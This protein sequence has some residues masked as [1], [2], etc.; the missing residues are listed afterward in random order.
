MNRIV[1]AVALL[2]SLA[3][4]YPITI[5]AASANAMSDTHVQLATRSVTI[6]P[7][8]LPLPVG[9]G[10]LSMVIPDT[11]YR[12]ANSPKSGKITLTNI[13][14]KFNYSAGGVNVPTVAAIGWNGGI[15]FQAIFTAKSTNLH[16]ATQASELYG[17]PVSTFDFHNASGQLEK[18]PTH[19]AG[20][21]K[22]KLYLASAGSVT[23]DITC[24]QP[25]VGKVA[26]VPTAVASASNSQNNPAKKSSSPILPILIIVALV[27][28]AAAF[29]L[30]IKEKRP[31]D[32]TDDITDDPE[33]I[34]GDPYE[35]PN[36]RSIF[37]SATT[38]LLPSEEPQE[39]FNPV[40]PAS[41][42]TNDDP[43]DREEIG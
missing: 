40:P 28:A 42:P 6:G 31:H 25:T 11:S 4:I 23:V 17:G 26:T 19:V 2:G 22:L 15:S 20:T 1:R 43:T 13:Y 8:G 14:C 32:W 34:M 7:D 3:I 9:S 41:T 24:A 35:R 29:V 27:A 12:G 5:F 37:R 10:T 36:W 38:P 16:L 39:G 21:V 33:G 18:F 30:K